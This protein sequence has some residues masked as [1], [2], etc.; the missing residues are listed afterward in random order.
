VATAPTTFYRGKPGTTTVTAYTVSAAMTGIVTN[1][2]LCN[3]DTAAATA[4]VFIADTPIIYDLPLQA[5]ETVVVDMAQPMNAGQQLKVQGSTAEV[6][7][8]IAGVV[9]G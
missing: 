3:A 6:A 8:H 1:V 7:I 2:L 9:T 5:G 4:Q